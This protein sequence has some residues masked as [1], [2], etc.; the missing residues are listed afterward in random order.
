M[1]KTCQFKTWCKGNKSNIENSTDHFCEDTRQNRTGC[2]YKSRSRDPIFTAWTPHHLII[3]WVREITSL[4]SKLPDQ[5]EVQVR[6]DQTYCLN[7]AVFWYSCREKSFHSSHSLFAQWRHCPC[8]WKIL[9]LL[10]LITVPGIKF[11]HRPKIRFFAP[12]GRLVAP[13]HVKLGR[14]DS[15]NWFRNFF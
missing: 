9:E 7:G 11:T 1:L 5:T 6:T 13:I 12:E 4:D 3:Q 15:V 10:N 8:C 2:P 14:G